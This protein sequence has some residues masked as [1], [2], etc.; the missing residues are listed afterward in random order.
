M[1]DHRHEPGDCP[2]PGCREEDPPGQRCEGA[3]STPEGQKAGVLYRGPLAR[4]SSSQQIA[5]LRKG[6]D[7]D[8]LTM[9]E[10]VTVLEAKAAKGGGSRSA[11]GTSAGK[12]APKA[13]GQ[14]R[15]D[16]RQGGRRR[17]RHSPAVSSRTF[18]AIVV[19]A[20]VAARPFKGMR[21]VQLKARHRPGRRPGLPGRDDVMN[22]LEQSG[23]ALAE[24]DLA[25]AFGV[26]AGTACAS[27]GCCATWR[28][29]PAAARAGA[30]P[31]RH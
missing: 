4:T 20:D 14:R 16:R 2:A 28:R 7:P 6:L 29:R 31:A 9:E 25:R 24:H 17:T 15:Q 12:R 27:S 23:G 18:R 26:R 21:K 19:A 8:Q 1:P 11:R 5:S 30:G 13:A 22:Y 3:R 10:A